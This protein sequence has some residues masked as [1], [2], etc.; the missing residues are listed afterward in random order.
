MAEVKPNIDTNRKKLADIVPLKAPFT[1]YIEQTRVCNLKCYYCIHSTRNE[2]GG[3][4][5]KLGYDIKH[6]HFDDFLKVINDLTEFPQGSIKKICFSGLGEPLTNPR[7]PEMVKITSEKKIADRVEI[8]TNGLLLTHKL[9][10]ALIEADITAI[11]IS[12]QGNNAEYYEEVC[13]KKINFESFLENLK[14]LYQ[15]K[16]QATI[17]IKAVD[18]TFKNKEDEKKFFEIFSPFADR[19]YVE[20]I[21]PMHTQHNA[22]FADQLD[23]QLDFY[24]RPIKMKS[25]ICCQSFYLLQI[26][27]DLDIFPCPDPGLERVLSLGNAKKQTLKEIWNGK[28]RKLH[29]KKML[30]FKRNEI[31]VCKDCQTFFICVNDPAEFLDDNAPELIKLFDD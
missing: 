14:Y 22:S 7:L 26:G 12:I 18:A 13:K 1:V 23:T 4:F 27:C 17:Y 2:K 21:I 6:M 9:T 15:N 8:I 29:L 20:H 10:D 3:A 5:Q 28:R 31:P 24:G 16:K 30:Q 25:D 11:N 19:I